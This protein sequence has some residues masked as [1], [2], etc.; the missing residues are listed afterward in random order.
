M[1]G[2]FGVQFLGS[3]FL[4][5]DDDMCCICFTTQL[6]I[7]QPQQGAMLFCTTNYKYFHPTGR[8]VLKKPSFFYILEESSSR[9]INF[10][11]SLNA[12]SGRLSTITVVLYATES[13]Y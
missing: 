1:R 3:R 11:I 6:E 4:V 7:A 12:T 13:T 9:S 10:L 5:L 8:F 2:G